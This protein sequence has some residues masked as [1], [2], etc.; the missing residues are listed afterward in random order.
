MP[1]HRTVIATNE[2]AGRF[3][4][5]QVMARAKEMF[6]N[7]KPRKSGAGDYSAVQLIAVYESLKKEG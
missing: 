4:N 2:E 3:T 6:P 1:R 7:V 5:E